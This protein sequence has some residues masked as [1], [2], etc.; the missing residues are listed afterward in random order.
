M[1]GSRPASGTSLDRLSLVKN[2]AASRRR[3]DMSNS[4]P[5]TPGNPGN[6][7]TTTT[8]GGT[9]GTQASEDDMKT[10]EDL[11]RQL[12][13]VRKDMRILAGMTRNS[14]GEVAGEL[15][16]SAASTMEGLSD[17][18][19]NMLGEARERGA[20]V[21]NETEESIRRHP[22][23]SIGIALAAGWVIGALARR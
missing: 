11:R 14:A 3:T 4:T 22:M 12:D 13:T 17:E 9:R 8:I 1:D 15:R 19:R 5:G 6:P 7:T 10:V 16:R 20:Q 2:H 23:A 21:Y 18:A